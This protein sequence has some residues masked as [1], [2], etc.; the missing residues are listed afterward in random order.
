VLDVLPVKCP[1][2]SGIAPVLTPLHYYT[3]RA[4]EEVGSYDDN[5]WGRAGVQIVYG[6]VPA[7]VS[8]I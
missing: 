7:R 2:P 8:M 4:R 1:K 3:M 5:D 6:M